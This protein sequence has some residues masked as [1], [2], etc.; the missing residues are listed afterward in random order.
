VLLQ[1]IQVQFP[2]STWQ[3]T[4]ICN[5]SSRES[6]AYFW[7]PKVLCINAVQ[8]RMKANNNIHKK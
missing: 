4:N 3:L 1:K 8:I 5:S 6:E 7:P 2:A